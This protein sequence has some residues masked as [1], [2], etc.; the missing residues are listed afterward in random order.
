MARYGRNGGGRGAE[1]ALAEAMAIMREP[2][3]SMLQTA[4]DGTL[5]A[6]HY[7]T[8]EARAKAATKRWSDITLER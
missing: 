3:F 1:A 6:Q 2:I 8:A 5:T 7:A 4:P